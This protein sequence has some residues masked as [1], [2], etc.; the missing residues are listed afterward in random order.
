MQQHAAAAGLTA[1]T[2]QLRFASAKEG[3]EVLEFEA[4]AAAKA[5][6][7]LVAGKV[8][9]RHA[10]PQVTISNQQRRLAHQL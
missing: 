1:N 4:P 7:A 6:A 2:A 8:K 5:V 9:L 3:R 10:A